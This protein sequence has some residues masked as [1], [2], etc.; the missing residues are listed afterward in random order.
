MHH[1]E[2]EVMAR[3]EEYHWWYRGLRD[4]LRRTLLHP[5]LRPPLA[6]SVLDAGCGTGANLRF[7]AELLE[8]AYL[9]GF[10]LSEQA[11]A[12][13]RR[14][15]SPF[16]ADLYQSDLCDPILPAAD[17]DLIVSLDVVSMTGVTRALPGLCRMTERLRVGG[18]LVLNLPAYAWLHSE[19]DV[20]VH[21]AERFTL[22]AVRDLLGT[23]GLEIVR[24]SYRLCALFPA[25]VA[26]R[27]P[28]L[29][30]AR[31]EDPKARSQLQRRSGGGAIDAA[32]LR[33]LQLEN[34][35]VARGVSLPFG[36]TVFAIGRKP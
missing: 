30:S 29:R 14:K 23:L 18:L 19:H 21:T 27:L 16:E 32:L 33:V 28:R 31:S 20:A 15:L 17:L 34:L 26:S 8:P 9:G 6:P 4:A 36:S 35:L 10:D 13:A 3:A 7:L 24:S 2:Y 12:L 5:D 22:G 25:V 11:L 1:D